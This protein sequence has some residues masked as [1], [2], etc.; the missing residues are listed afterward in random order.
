MNK[1]TP[2]S[3][4]TSCATVSPAPAPLHRAVT[5]ALDAQAS[6]PALCSTSGAS[7]ALSFKSG[8]ADSGCQR[9]TFLAHQPSSRR[10]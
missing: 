8:D 10:A 5:Q 1:A 6:P 4:A 3:L 2:T 9:H 7:P